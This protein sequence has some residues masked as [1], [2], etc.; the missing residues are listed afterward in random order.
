MSSSGA[1][2]SVNAV[3]RSWPTS[4]LYWATGI[5]TTLALPLFI[6]E[7]DK[8]SHLILDDYNKVR[9]DELYDFESLE[10]VGSFSLKFLGRLPVASW[11]PCGTDTRFEPSPGR[12]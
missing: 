2:D 5:I 12:G 3:Q 8:V 4:R 6:S 11:R 1:F 9:V 7:P 10:S